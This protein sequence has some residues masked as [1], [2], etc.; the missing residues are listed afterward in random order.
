MRDIEIGQQEIA[1]KKLDL[2][3]LYDDFHNS[4]FSFVLGA[5]QVAQ[6][7]SEDPSGRPYQ[8]PEGTNP[9]YVAMQMTQQKSV[10]EIESLARKHIM[11]AMSDAS[12]EN[13]DDFLSDF[14]ESDLHLD[15]IED[16][17]DSDDDTED[18]KDDD[19]F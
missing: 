4:K 5:I 1:S 16:D 3:H 11:L 18:D 15:D 9:A 13:E 2:D 12:M 19:F 7:Y 17:S 8:I 6:E 10:D 14:N